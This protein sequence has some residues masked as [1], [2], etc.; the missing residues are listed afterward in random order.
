MENCDVKRVAALYRVSTKKQV[1]KR[2]NDIPVQKT[3]CHEFTELRG[4]PIVFE[5]CEK[6]V[7][8]FKTSANDRDAI[9]ELK[10]LAVKKAFD[11][12]LVFMFDRL[13][14]IDSETPFVVE[15]FVQ[16]GIEVWS[17]KEGQQKLEDHADKLIN[18]VRFWQANG[19]SSKTSMRV[20][21]SFSQM[22]AAGIF[23]GG[24]IGFGYQ[25]VH[26]G[27][28]NKKGQPVK[29]KVVH[30]A[31]AEVL[32]DIL[33]KTLY[34]GYGTHRLAAYVNALGVR[35]H[36]GKK[37]TATSILRIL[38]NK[39]YCGYLISGGIVSEKIPELVI[40]DENEFDLVND[41]LNQR[42]IKYEEKQNIARTTKGQ[43]L[44]SGNIYCGHCGCHL[45]A[46]KG[47]DQYVRKDGSVYRK[48]TVRYTCYHKSRGLNDCD[49][50]S[51]Y[52]AEKID[53]MV[54]EI[55]KRYLARIKQ[56]PKDKALE[57]RYKNELRQKK[58]QRKKLDDEKFRLGKRLREAS[59]EI[60]KSLT[61]ESV[62]STD[63]LSM[64]INAIKEDLTRIEKQIATCET[65]L[66]AKDEVLRKLDFYY[67]QFVSWADEFEN[68]SLEQK[69][70]IICQLIKSVTVRKGYELDIEFNISY[71]QFL[72]LNK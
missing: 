15:W 37:F 3:A 11:V 57:L 28:V 51:V 67:D 43:T 62:F 65:E 58:L 33:H 72:A 71:Q 32:R 70:M 18:Y 13:G 30:E 42:S 55:V 38:R 50:Q 60:G 41:I 17:V 49:G 4:W 12:L 27:R 68:A 8:G 59:M 54:A 7:S 66:E 47:V 36:N 20:K 2:V 25:L 39:E 29:D 6:G 24:Q 14:R 46:A 23:H 53:T 19:E 69:K 9:Q 1:D 22:T 31:E 48:E 35:T 63:V 40:W 26:Q 61:G 52:I 34:E 56:T 21:T 5:F 10:E 16:H 44:L 45:N 64:S